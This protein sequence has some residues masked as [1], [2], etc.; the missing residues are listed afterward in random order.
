MQI[1]EYLN[2]SSAC[3]ICTI[4]SIMQPVDTICHR[5]A[6]YSMLSYCFDILN[7]RTGEFSNIW[8]YDNQRQPPPPQKKNRKKR[9]STCSPTSFVEIRLA[10]A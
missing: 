7:L 4:L 10:V 2:K 9:L 5:S 8:T 3:M 6:S 1:G